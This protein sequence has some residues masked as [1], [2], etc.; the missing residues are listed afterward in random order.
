MNLDAITA[1]LK[2]EEADAAA[3]LERALD[4]ARQ[5]PDEDVPDAG[6][7]GQQAA[8]KDRHLTDAEA[9]QRHLEAVRAALARIEAGTYGLCAVDGEPI[10]PDR[11]E[12]VPWAAL[13]LE[14]QEAREGE[15]N[16]PTL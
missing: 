2:Q 1:R 7:L 11:L 4:A 6:D 3:R 5:G 14:H 9:A 12:A 16:T 13:C 15:T 10:E 8:A